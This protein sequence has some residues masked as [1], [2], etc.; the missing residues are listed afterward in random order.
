MVGLRSLEDQPSSPRQ[1][2][3]LPRLVSDAEAYSAPR[4]EPDTVGGNL[5]R[6]TTCTILDRSAPAD[7]LEK[8]ASI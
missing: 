3:P 5:S 8:G 6:S 2:P 4:P 7:T 1:L